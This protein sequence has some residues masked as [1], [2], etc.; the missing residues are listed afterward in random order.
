MHGHTIELSH[1]AFVVKPFPS[2]FMEKERN[3]W[4]PS[5]GT[6]TT[7]TTEKTNHLH[8]HKKGSKMH[9]HIQYIYI[10]NG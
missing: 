4:V 2:P 10:F 9:S 7:T 8:H 6:T 1:V 3:N 5:G